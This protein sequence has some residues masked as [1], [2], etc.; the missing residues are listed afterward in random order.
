MKHLVHTF[1]K[2]FPHWSRLL[3]ENVAV[4]TGTSSV[5]PAADLE[6]SPLQV[7]RWEPFAGRP[8]AEMPSRPETP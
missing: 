4:V 3:G 5:A 2:P 1:E 8:T 7:C 6:C